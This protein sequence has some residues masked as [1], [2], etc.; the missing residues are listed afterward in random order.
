MKCLRCGRCCIC[1]NIFV[2]DPQ[3]ILLDSSLE[4]KDPHSMIFKPG[5]RPCP[6]LKF[7]GDLAV[8]NIHELQCYEGTPCQQFEQLGMENDP[9]MMGSYLEIE[10]GQK[11]FEDSRCCGRLQE[12]ND[13]FRDLSL[14]G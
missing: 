10:M 2:V 7:Q 5:G 4:T 3:S 9:C 11:L 1:L 14:Q 12:K 6:H 8:C 13:T